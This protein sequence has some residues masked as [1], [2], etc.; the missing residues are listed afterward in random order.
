MDS[1]IRIFFN[2]PHLQKVFIEVL[3]ICLQFG[4]FIIVLQGPYMPNQCPFCDIEASRIQLENGVGI[5]ILDAFPVSEGHTLVIPKKHVVSLYD[6]PTNEQ[7]ALWQLVSEV[8]SNLSHKLKPD[9]FNI[10]INDGR[11][12][13]QTVMHAHI[14]VIP[15]RIGDDPDPRG[16]IRR[17]NTE[18]AKYWTETK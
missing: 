12:A 1:L 6:L 10:G 4:I 5:A 16:G 17:V 9:G 14:H 13:G 15:R 2:L 11:A 3:E 8:R 7:A 18:K